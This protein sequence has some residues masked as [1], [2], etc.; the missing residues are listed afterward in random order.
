M[1]TPTFATDSYMEPAYPTDLFSRLCT[2]EDPVANSTAAK[3]K[4]FMLDTLNAGP[5]IRC[6][7]A[8][9][10]ILDEI[11]VPW[12]KPKMGGVCFV[13]PDDF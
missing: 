9:V 12:G 7:G 10:V 3:L 6:L 2:R 8:A 11:A 1:Y 5:G 4:A 13:G